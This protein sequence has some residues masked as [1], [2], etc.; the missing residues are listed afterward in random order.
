M[1]KRPITESGLT[2]S[3]W[4][5]QRKLI[6]GV[7]V[8]CLLAILTSGASLVA[9]PVLIANMAGLA[10]GEGRN[11]TGAR[12]LQLAGMNAIADI[13]A[14]LLAG[15]KQF[16]PAARAGSSLVRD[17]ATNL[18]PRMTDPEGRALLDAVLA[19][20]QAHR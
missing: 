8:I 11:L 16:A 1:P 13:Q 18:R 7:I 10:T 15:G 2:V 12:A 14:C 17:L 4:S 9:S 20:E 19:A 5:F 3:E 6:T